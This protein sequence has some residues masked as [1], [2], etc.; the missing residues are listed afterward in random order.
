[1]EVIG[2]IDQMADGHTVDQCMTV[3]WGE[4]EKI[5]LVDG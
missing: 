4:S 1:M 3:T 5:Q 2:K